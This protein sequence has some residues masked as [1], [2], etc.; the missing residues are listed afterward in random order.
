MTPD[1]IKELPYPV[2][3]CDKEGI[4][5]A[6]NDSSVNEF[7]DDGGR[8]LI[9][10][11]V[12]DCHPEPSH[13]KLKEML[14]EEKENIYIIDKNGKR[15]MICQTPWYKDGVYSGFAEISISLPDDIPVHKR[16]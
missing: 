4:I 2:T 16:D 10:T 5:I 9:G 1:W 13:T 6:M 3:L 12:L 8:E 7:E 15:K 14:A 11:N